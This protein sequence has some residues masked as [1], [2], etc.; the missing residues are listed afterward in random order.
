MPSVSLNLWT[1]YRIFRRI[2]YRYSSV[3]VSITEVF[4]YNCIFNVV[5]F[6]QELF[7][8]YIITGH[9][10][11]AGQPFD[12]V[13]RGRGTKDRRNGSVSFPSVYQSIRLDLAIGYWGDCYRP[14]IALGLLAHS[15]AF[16]SL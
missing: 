15:D 6:A 10:S 13:G 16:V 1:G 14:G 7:V 3:Y 5:L 9:C 2:Y 4:S 8:M 11:I 12:N